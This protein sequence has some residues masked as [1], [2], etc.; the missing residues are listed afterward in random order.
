MTNRTGIMFPPPF[1]SSL[2]PSTISSV[3]L[4]FSYLNP[5]CTN[6]SSSSI[7]PS[8]SLAIFSLL[9]L[10]SLLLL[11]LSF[12]TLSITLQGLLP[13]FQPPL[14]FSHPSIWSLT[15]FYSLCTSLSI[16]LITHSLSSILLDQRTASRRVSI[17]LTVTLVSKPVSK[18]TGS[19]TLVRLSSILSS[20]KKYRYHDQIFAI[21]NQIL[22]IGFFI[23]FLCIYYFTIKVYITQYLSSYNKGTL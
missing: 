11:H 22:V 12:P 13:P 6:C 5:S 10:S 3:L 17:A 8:V 7:L 23:L 2:L 16:S 4:P 19:W 18:N 14:R 1:I 21:E 15:S 20:Q 9:I